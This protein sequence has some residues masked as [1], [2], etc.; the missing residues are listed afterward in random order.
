MENFL[1][2]TPEVNNFEFFDVLLE[3]PEKAEKYLE[4]MQEE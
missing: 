3:S 1:F 4:H 2:L